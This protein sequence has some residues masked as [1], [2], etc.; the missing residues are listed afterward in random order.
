MGSGKSTVVER[1]GGAPEPLDKWGVWLSLFYGNPKRYGLG[2]QMKVLLEFCRMGGKI[3]ERSPMDAL[4]V[5]SA[6]LLQNGD[7]TQ[8]EFDLLSE[9][10]AKFGWT[11]DV[12][13]YIRT[14]PA[15]CLQ[16]VQR[17]GRECEASITLELL[18]AI[19]EKYEKLIR[20]LPCVHVVDG[21]QDP[22]KVLE[23][24]QNIL[25]VY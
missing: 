18:Q 3:T 8:D 4:H 20:T 19:H 11:P 7:L 15:V 22:S 6:L 1:L 23:A 9:Y 12:Y 16:R 5:F 25:Y 13:V 24:V 2:F 21:N 17:R 14:D 10:T